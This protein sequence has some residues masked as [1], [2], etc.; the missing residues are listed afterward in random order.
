MEQVGGQRHVKEPR[1]CVERSMVLSAL[2][3]GAQLLELRLR[4]LSQCDATDQA[5]ATRMALWVVS[6]AGY[7]AK[8]TT[9]DLNSVPYAEFSS[10]GGEGT[11]GVLSAQM[12]WGCLNWFMV[13]SMYCFQQRCIVS[14][15][16]LEGPP[17]HLLGSCALEACS[18]PAWVRVPASAQGMTLPC[19]QV[20]CGPR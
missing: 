8:G 11:F 3:P 19:S 13:R 7:R 14:G 6:C 2:C 16:T 12:R 20:L 1:G 5:R 18:A 9:G 17:S 10:Q 15:K 4:A